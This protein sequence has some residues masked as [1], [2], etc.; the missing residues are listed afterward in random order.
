MRAWVLTSA[1]GSALVAAAAA[2]QQA[3]VFRS[4]V[5]IVQVDVSVVDSN[6]RPVRGLTSSDF[7]LLENGRR[8]D[9]V[10]F[11]AVNVPETPAQPATWLRD[12]PPDVRSNRLG[13]GRLF[14]IIMDDATMPPDV[15]IAKTARDAARGVIARLG[16][17]DL[18]AV[19]FVTDSRRSVDFTNDRKRLVAA[20]DGFT[21]AFAF[22]DQVSSTD[23][24]LYYA[25][26]RTLGLVSASLTRVPQRRKAIIYVS[27]GVPVEA[28]TVA[29]IGR[30]GPRGTP[31]LD[32]P[33]AGSM[34]EETTSRDLVEAMT[35]I[36][37]VRPQDAYG[38][39]MHDAFIRAQNGNVNIYS[40]DPAGATGM[41]NYL[42]TRVRTGQVGG[43]AM[44]LADAMLESHL[45]RDFLET[46]AENSG[47]LAI[48]AADHLERGLARVFA[49]NSTYYLLGYQAAPRAPGDKSLR[50]VTVKV[51]RSGATARTRN[52]YFSSPPASSPSPGGVLP[53]L[54]QT[55]S[56]VLPN[57]DVTLRG[58]A[59]AFGIPGGRAGLALAVG[60]EQSV[61]GDAGARV[62]DRL[63]VL[64]AAYSPDGKPR[65]SS[66]QTARIVLRAGLPDVAQYEVLSRI[67]LAPGL[68]QIRLAAH[69]AMTGKTGSVYF[70]VAVPDFERAPFELSGVVLS[71]T[72]SQ[73]A[74]PTDAAEAFLPVVPTSQRSFAQSDF[75]VGF[76]RIYQGVGRTPMPI[77]LSVKITDGT[78]K[79]VV[80]SSEVLPPE[81][82]ATR[83][84]DVR[85]SVPLDTLAAGEYL[86]TVEGQ[87][88]AKTIRRDIRFHVR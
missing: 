75:A 77:M 86:I 15:R 24:Q 33:I 26:I 7:T 81:R 3:P 18:A 12:I 30:M 32:V 36:L 20:I 67:D 23:N 9:V 29:S 58:T 37:E 71:A 56:G 11:A 65:G 10:A 35:E 66:Q 74:G 27:T 8:Q 40:V 34:M 49:D 17:D 50:R 63:D 46:I 73:P 13:D 64:A 88:G 79:V 61:V 60:I 47:G 55:L 31:A 6:G 21:P 62:Q 5:D 4:G 69:S 16:P 87:L 68:Y 70:D 2:Q 83:Q 39:A 51:G 53:T 48:V 42:Q 54:A 82:F 44:T 1:L 28:D 25:S 76:V 80:R 45:H 85:F 72:P 57:P 78:D 19:I 59:A 41:Q 84:A 52:A 14:A 43:K 22:N 38:A